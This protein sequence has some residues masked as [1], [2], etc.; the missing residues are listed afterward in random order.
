LPVLLTLVDRRAEGRSPRAARKG[1]TM[2]S[3][4]C[5][6]V[7]SGLLLALLGHAPAAGAGEP[8]EQ[9]RADIDELYRSV[10]GPTTAP[11]GQDQATRAIVDR[12][13]DWTAM[14]EASLRGRWRQRTPTERTEFTQ[15]FADVFA[16][17]Y[18]SRIHLVD[19]TTFQYLGDTTAGEHATVRTKV[20]TKRGSAIAVDYVVQ[21]T[22]AARWRVQDIRVESISLVDNYRVQFETIIARSSYQDLVQRLRATAK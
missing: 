7:V 3:F 22:N 4:Q 18:M 10:H 6:L 13:F 15:L 9:L 12:M 20:L 11:A 14:A 2:S 8:T 17:A 5:V 21:A 1:A 19:A 16:R